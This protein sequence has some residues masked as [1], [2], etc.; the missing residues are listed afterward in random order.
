[1]SCLSRKR[2][3]LPPVHKAWKII[4]RG[5]LSQINNLKNSTFVRRI[6]SFSPYSPF[7]GRCQTIIPR[8][9]Y[10]SSYH[11]ASPQKNYY[12]PIYI[13]ELFGRHD[14]TNDKARGS[15]TST[16][17]ERS[18][19]SKD[20]LDER[21]R[22]E[23]GDKMSYCI[24][25]RWMAIVAKSPQLCSVDERAEEFIG[26]FKEEM[27]LERER[28]IL[29]FQEMIRRGAWMLEGIFLDTFGLFEVW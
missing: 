4:T 9:C 8:T 16:K 23:G 18:R 25:E 10:P 15:A 24:D 6:H 26:R 11:H 5:F 27:K 29:E 2:K 1:M 7:K 28:S 21:K 22:D 17:G 3:L 14:R 19:S 13:E 12:A 20:E